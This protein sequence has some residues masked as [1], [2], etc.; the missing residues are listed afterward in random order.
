MTYRILYTNTFKKALKL[1]LKRGCDER[2]FACVIEM[3]K[4]TGKL[5]LEYHP[6]ILSGRL[7]GY[8]ECHITS[9]WLLIWKQDD[10]EMTV[11]LA[12]TGTHSDIF[13]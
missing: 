12:D 11:T 4:T 8:T 13:G 5:P 2:K 9:D 1:C 6:H 7:A 3:L 10:S